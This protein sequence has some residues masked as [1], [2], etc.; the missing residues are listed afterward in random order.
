MRFVEVTELNIADAGRIHSE[1][2]KEA[3]RSFCS[4]AFVEKHTPM[5]QA[6][7][8]R[9]EMDAGNIPQI[10]QLALG[11]FT[12]QAT[13]GNL[14]LAFTI[15]PAFAAFKD[16]MPPFLITTKRIDGLDIVKGIACIGDLIECRIQRL[17]FFS[18]F[19]RTV[20]IRIAFAVIKCHMIPL[21]LR[22]IVTPPDLP[23]FIFPFNENQIS[24]F[25]H[26]LGLKQGLLSAY[27]QSFNGAVIKSLLTHIHIG[28]FHNICHRKVCITILCIN[29]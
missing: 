1:S 27:G 8:L 26:V 11:A 5:A 13:L 28:M 23:C 22:V 4:A 14:Q 7:Y 20:S 3:H 18:P 24:S 6:A 15:S 10:I 21:I 29:K 2:W 25:I 12:F 16:N 9:R 17:R 19:H